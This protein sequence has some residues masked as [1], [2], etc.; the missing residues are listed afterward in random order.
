MADKKK[1]GCKPG[2]SNFSHEDTI[3][4]GSVS[5]KTSPAKLASCRTNALKHGQY[6]KFGWVVLGE[7]IDLKS[8]IKETLEV[9][10]RMQNNTMGDENGLTPSG[11]IARDSPQNLSL[12]MNH[13]INLLKI[14][15]AGASQNQEREDDRKEDL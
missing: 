8:Y 7:E 5:G 9:L 3:R 12:L 15:L 14:A 11:E 6:S 2:T 4:G 1:R 13:R 10:T